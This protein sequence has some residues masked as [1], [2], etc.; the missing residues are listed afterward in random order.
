M[1]V[2]KTIRFQLNGTP[3]EFTI[4]AGETLLDLL[5]RSDYT[6]TKR[7]C[8]DGACG[9]CTVLLDGAAINSCITFAF[10]AHE[11]EVVTIEGIGEYDRPSPFQKAMVEAAGVQCGFCIPGIV[12]SVKALL[13]EIPNPT[14]Q[15]ILENLDGN[16]CRCTGYEKIEDALHRTIAE[17]TGE[18]P[19]WTR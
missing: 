12:L 2:E 17:T 4:T 7:G 16:Y 14:Q 8:E 9:S 3:R 11:R 6:G 19:Q 10:Q 13:D 1:S 15:Q 5:R 18:E